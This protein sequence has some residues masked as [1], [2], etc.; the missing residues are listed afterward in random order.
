MLNTARFE[1]LSY[2]DLTRLE[3]EIAIMKIKRHDNERLALKAKMEA[4]IK[5]AG[6]TVAEVFGAPKRAARKNGNGNGHKL[7]PK[8]A[9]PENRSQT[10]AGRG[11]MPRWMTAAMKQRGA[12]REDFAVH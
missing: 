4:A 10:W 2:K 12:K 9:N 7:A 1:K 5:E 6:F 3:G 8:Y 11:R